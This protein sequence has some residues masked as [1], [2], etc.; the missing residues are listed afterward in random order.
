MKHPKIIV[1][2]ALLVGLVS[3]T[4]MAADKKAYEASCAA[5][6]EARKMSAEM[7]YEWNTIA[8][9]MAKA[10]EAAG[11]GD[12]D[13]AVKLCEEARLHSEAAIAQAKKQ[14]DMWKAAVV[15]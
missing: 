8:P 15:R 14:A 4:S 7:R 12:Y 13:K 3:G 2:V 9:L 10:D 1:G 5:A 11:A 6:E